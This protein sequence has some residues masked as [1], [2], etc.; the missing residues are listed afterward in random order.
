MMSAF[1]GGAAPLRAA[2]APQTAPAARAQ[3]PA[4][5][6][7]SGA[8]PSPEAAV[9]VAAALAIG[10]RGMARRTA[11]RPAGRTARAAVKGDEIKRFSKDADDD[12][13]EPDPMSLVDRARALAESLPGLAPLAGKVVVIKYGGAA[14]VKKPERT[15]KDVAL[16]KALGLKPVLIHGGGPEING[17][18]D[19]VGIE[20][21]FSGGLR[22]TDDA[23]MEI[24]GMVLMGKVNKTIVSQMGAA[25]VK[26]L[27]LG[28]VDAQLI[29]AKP[30]DPALGL[31]NVGEVTGVNVDLLRAVLDAGYLPVIATVATDP[32]G[33]FLNVNAD[34]AAAAIAGALSAPEFVLMT[35]VPGIL[36]DVKDMGSLI[37]EVD[38]AGAEALITDGVV[39]GGMIPKVRCC[40]D[41]IEAGVFATHII[42]GRR[43]HSLIEEL[44]GTAGAKQGTTIAKS[45]S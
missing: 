33:K 39:A 13:P 18:L 17:W 35:D 21:K 32:D 20:P 2:L 8:V 14:M 25:G 4:V 6:L 24:V 19:K 38:V 15:I 34:T 31:G 29:Q 45:L 9:A 43:P 12:E 37:S 10:A 23:T 5:Q 28:G 3:A 26:A 27:G 16:L 1:V 30:V 42:D 22:V 41:A 7:A 11:R 44:L 40:L 36:K